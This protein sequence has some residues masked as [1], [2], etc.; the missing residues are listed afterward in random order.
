MRNQGSFCPS[1]FE[2][3]MLTYGGDYKLKFQTESYSCYKKAEQFQ[4]Y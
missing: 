4:E 1:G 2:E 3:F